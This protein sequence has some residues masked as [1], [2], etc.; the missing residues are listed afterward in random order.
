M[1]MCHWT[2]G[3][4]AVVEWQVAISR[5]RVSWKGSTCSMC[6]LNLY[7]SIPNKSIHCEGFLH[8]LHDRDGTGLWR[9][10]HPWPR[11]H[12]LR[13]SQSISSYLCPNESIAIESNP[14]SYP[15]HGGCKGVDLCRTSEV[16]HN[17]PL[18][19]INSSII[20]LKTPSWFMGPGGS[21]PHSQWLSNNHMAIIWK[22]EISG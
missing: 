21:M 6:V 12:M 14:S 5:Y 2:S 10:R 9:G 11:A 8:H 4:H 17:V 15:V 7:H 13:V 1:G 22:L 19:L 16:Y 18:P 3:F 20:K